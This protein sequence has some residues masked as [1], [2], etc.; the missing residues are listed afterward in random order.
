[1]RLTDIAPRSAR[2][3]VSLDAPD[4]TKG[5]R[6]TAQYHLRAH[7]TDSV[8]RSTTQPISASV[9][10]AEIAGI[11]G[12]NHWRDQRIVGTRHRHRRDLFNRAP[13]L[14]G[15]SAS[16]QQTV[17]LGSHRPQLFGDEGQ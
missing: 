8:T 1:M 17:T 2:F 12:C 11:E 14:R 5:V 16:T 3:L 10:I 4:R 7:R 9:R 13:A 15:H 6:V